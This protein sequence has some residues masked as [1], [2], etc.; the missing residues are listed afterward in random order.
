MPPFSPLSDD[1]SKREEPLDKTVHV[2]SAVVVQLVAWAPGCMDFCLFPMERGAVVKQEALLET[3]MSPIAPSHRWRGWLLLAPTVL[4]R[5]D[6]ADC[7]GFCGRAM[8][9]SKWLEDLFYQCM[10]CCVHFELQHIVKNMI[11]FF[12]PKTTVSLP[13]GEVIM[14]KEPYYKI[15]IYIC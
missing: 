8:L 9:R 11:L 10:D 2:P 4:P 13:T 15:R 3:V 14:C 12:F 5:F 7:S 1:R 6:Q